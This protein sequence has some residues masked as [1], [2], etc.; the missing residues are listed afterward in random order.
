MTVPQCID[1]FREMAEKVFKY[2]KRLLWNGRA[3]YKSSHVKAA[4]KKVLLK[5]GFEEDEK[6]LISGPLSNSHCRT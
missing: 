4:V 1:A 2:G 6:L 5:W 3:R